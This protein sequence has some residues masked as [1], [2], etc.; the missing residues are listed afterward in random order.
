MTSE[1]EKIPNKARVPCDTWVMMGPSAEFEPGGEELRK[2]V[3]NMIFVEVEGR[4]HRSRLLEAKCGS[5][6]CSGGKRAGEK[7]GNYLHIS[8]K[9]KSSRKVWAG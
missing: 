5:Q 2:R 7:I 3:M 8:Q 6:T 9:C 1:G 4:G